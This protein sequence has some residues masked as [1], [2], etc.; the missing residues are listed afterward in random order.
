M[1]KAKGGTGKRVI[2]WVLLTIVVV[3][4]VVVAA[5]P[6]ALSS[7]WGRKL[8]TAQLSKAVQ[9][10][11]SIG[12][13]KLSWTGGQA[14]HD[15][16]IDVPRPGASLKV[17]IPDVTMSEAL[18]RQLFGQ[19][20]LG[21][22]AVVSPKVLY[23]RLNADGTPIGG[24]V[25]VAVGHSMGS[26]TDGQ[27]QQAQSRIP[28]D[29]MTTQPAPATVGSTQ[30]V[31]LPFI[32]DIEIMDGDVTITGLDVG[33]VLFSDIS[34]N[35]TIPRV[36][37]PVMA[38]LSG[39]S[40]QGGTGGT[41]ALHAWVEGLDS[42][43]KLT[44][45]SAQGE[46]WRFA[47]GGKLLADAEVTNFP[48]AAIDELLTGGEGPLMALFGGNVDLSLS[49]TLNEEGAAFAL[50]AVGPTLDLSLDAT[51]SK[52]NVVATITAAGANI[53]IPGVKIEGS[54]TGIALAGPAVIKA[55]LPK[56]LLDSFLG[57]DHTLAL[58]PSVTITATI[59][60]AA[61]PCD[62]VGR[63]IFNKAVVNATCATT[64][65]TVGGIPQVGTIAV[66]AL[67][68][69][70]GG[71][72]LAKA[73]VTVT[74]TLAAVGATAPLAPA[75]GDNASIVIATTLSVD[76]H[77]TVALS[78]IIASL[79]APFYDATF[80][81]RLDDADRL[82][83]TAPAAIRY[84]V[85]PERFALLR[86]LTTGVP[87]K[88][89]API[90]T[91]AS[92]AEITGEVTALTLPLSLA[93]GTGLRD[94][95]ATATVS[96]DTVALS[97]GKSSAALSGIRASVNASPLSK[98]VAFHCEGRGQVADASTADAGS[99]VIYGTAT[100][101]L[102]AE[103]NL[104]TKGM[105]AKLSADIKKLPVALLANA[106]GLQA[107]TLE[108]VDALL[109]DSADIT[110]SADLRGL[111]GPLK[112]DVK[113]SNSTLTFNGALA[114]GALTLVKPLKFQATMTPKL[115][116]VILK[117]IN[118]LLI[119]AVGSDRPLRFDVDVEGFYLPLV[120]FDKGKVQVGRATLDVGKVVLTNG[121]PMGI[122]ISILRAHKVEQLKETTA[123]F[124]RQYISMKD[125][126]VTVERMDLLVADAFH[127]ATWGHI[128]WPKNSAALFLGLSPQAVK[129]AFGIAMPKGNMFVIEMKGT[130]D[131][132]KI[133]TKKTTAR[134]AALI[135]TGKTGKTGQIIGQL[136]DASGVDIA[137]EKPPAPTTQPFPWEGDA[138]VTKAMNTSEEGVEPAAP[139]EP[140]DKAKEGNTPENSIKNELKRFF[141][142]L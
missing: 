6:T 56:A 106:M 46:I 51:A 90:L 78:D 118:P 88:G 103:G 11:V 117:D 121:G 38:Q 115:S 34:A 48:V 131:K 22:I 65:F 66:T 43:G 133:D 41:F 32:G 64:L 138:S 30:T 95:T 96:I 58:P 8:V 20:K 45:E 120:P 126:A 71:D 69:D 3:A 112:A 127:L 109:G 93:S 1:A 139:T 122:I 129:K 52:G 26:A 5:L 97:D 124:T 107:R 123:W 76:D 79:H 125:G 15:I 31:R 14:L 67:T 24:S 74:A 18:W 116:Q 102:D 47:D 110:A 10:D 80:Q 35:V 16:N 21:R 50:K 114:D 12:A 99:I 59:G 25:P 94:V 4:L 37:G 85:T 17:T 63:C 49:H 92:P 75:I 70:I 44:V 27:G 36:T 68:A 39:S 142:K 98:G 111:T 82:V 134:V 23:Q 54:S 7:P 137:G 53:D 57:H 140:V 101:I 72:T 33:T 61:F 119:T 105:E 130:P 135:A 100:D 60:K 84:T 132:I 136:L 87:V 19:L 83:L 13:L 62:G 89:K 77:G 104:S 91:L 42:S 86:A 28:Q 141:K 108:R 2:M 113:S 29:K 81:G 9:G 128:N 40:L 55:T 73:P